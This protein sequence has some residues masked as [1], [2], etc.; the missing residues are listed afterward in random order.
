VHAHNKIKQAIK[1]V[2]KKPNISSYDGKWN[3]PNWMAL[4]ECQTCQ[5]TLLIVQWDLDIAPLF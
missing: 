3:N 1:V 4:G 5:M 2:V